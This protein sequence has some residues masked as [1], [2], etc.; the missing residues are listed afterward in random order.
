M[1]VA[2]VATNT[3]L[4]NA[5]AAFVANIDDNATLATVHG[6]EPSGWGGGPSWRNPVLIGSE[7]SFVVKTYFRKCNL[8]YL[9]QNLSLIYS[10]F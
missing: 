3:G 7:V 5:P 9:I 6:H 4:D 8:A 10:R 1:A 2:L